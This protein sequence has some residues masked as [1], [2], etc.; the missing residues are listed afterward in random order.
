MDEP[1]GSTTVI[2]LVNSGV[3]TVVDAAVNL[4]CFY[5]FTKDDLHPWLSFEGFPSIKNVDSWWAIDKIGPG[6]RFTKD[7]KES[8]SRCLQHKQVIE[9]I[10]QMNFK[11]MATILAVDVVYHR[12][13]DHKRYEWSGIA[14]LFEDANT[15]KPFLQPIPLTDFYR[16][17]LKSTTGPL[18]RVQSQPFYVL[19]EK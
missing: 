13:F 17:M 16:S 6:D 8:L 10:P 3:Q 12:P 18:Y 4:R 11:V 2:A 7:S 5:Q 15:G 9:Q 14:Q 19:I 1:F